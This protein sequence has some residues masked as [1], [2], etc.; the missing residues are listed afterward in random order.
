MPGKQSEFTGCFRDFKKQNKTKDEF[1]NC[2]LYVDWSSFYFNITLSACMNYHSLPVSMAGHFFTFFL[3][4][5]MEKTL[6]LS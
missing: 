4:G 1:Q 3:C 2:M 5:V 6:V